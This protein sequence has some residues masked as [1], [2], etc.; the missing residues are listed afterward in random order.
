MEDNLRKTPSQPDNSVQLMNQTMMIQELLRENN[1]L[2][3]KNAY[4]NEKITMLINRHISQKELK[5][6]QL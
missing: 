1:E 6:K 4:L 5:G 2:K 3:A